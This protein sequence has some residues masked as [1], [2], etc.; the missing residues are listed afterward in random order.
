MK[1]GPR[2]TVGLRLPKKASVGFCGPRQGLGLQ[3]KKKALL[4]LRRPSDTDPF[5]RAASRVKFVSL[6][7]REKQKKK[8][9]PG[10]RCFRRATPRKFFLRRAAPRRA[11]FFP[12]RAAPR[13]GPWQK[14]APRL[15][16]L[17]NP[18]LLKRLLRRF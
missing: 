6:C 11:N 16:T 17:V 2:A 7:T 18:L 12:R 14:T 15:E 3:K 5:H 9:R 10:C 8:N 1:M 13:R 4:R